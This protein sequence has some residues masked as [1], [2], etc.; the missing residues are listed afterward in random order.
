MGSANP[1]LPTIF[2]FDMQIASCTT[3]TEEIF[4]ISRRHDTKQVKASVNC[5][6]TRFCLS[7]PLFLSGLISTTEMESR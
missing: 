5:L 7:G 2:T 1:C 6:I 4:P 3:R